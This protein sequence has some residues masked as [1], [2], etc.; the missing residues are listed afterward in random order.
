MT[1]RYK[2]SVSRTALEGQS[3]PP[4]DLTH[5]ASPTVDPIYIEKSRGNR[6]FLPNLYRVVTLRI[7][8]VAPLVETVP[9][10]TYGGTERIV[11]YL[12]EE[13]VRLGEHVTLFA[14]GGSTTNAELVPISARSLRADPDLKDPLTKAY[15]KLRRCL[16]EQKNSMWSTFRT[17]ICTS[18]S[19][20]VYR[21]PP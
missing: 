18:R 19:R 20:A 12:T 21:S 2:A 1:F 3:F 13:L 17:A 4:S 7:A 15:S 16:N 10:E 5:S 6:N 9:P 14:S 8:Q 11:S